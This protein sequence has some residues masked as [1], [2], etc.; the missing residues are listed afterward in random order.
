LGGEDQVK[1]V[2]E[3]PVKVIEHKPEGGENE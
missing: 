3:L 1:I 2:K